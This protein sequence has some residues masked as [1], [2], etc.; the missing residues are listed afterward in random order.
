MSARLEEEPYEIPDEPDDPDEDPVAPAI[1]EAG[2]AP[3]PSVEPGKERD[4]E[5]RVEVITIEEVLDGHTLADRLSAA[6]SEEWHL[7]DIIDAGDR[8][9]ILLRKRRE[10][11]AE[12]RRVGF[13]PMA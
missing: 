6:S 12:R 11:K 10:Q 3:V 2:S 7:V 13:A 5:Y 8:K 4:Y 1:A 9:A